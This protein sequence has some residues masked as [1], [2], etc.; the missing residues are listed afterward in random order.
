MER[1]VKFWPYAWCLQLLKSSALLPKRH[2]YNSSLRKIMVMRT[3]GWTAQSVSMNKMYLSPAG[4]DSP[5]KPNEPRR[6][7]KRTS[8]SSCSLG[9]HEN[10]TCKLKC[11][12][13]RS[14]STTYN[15]KELNWSDLKIFKKQVWNWSGQSFAVQAHQKI[16]GVAYTRRL[17]GRLAPFFPPSLACWTKWER[18]VGIKKK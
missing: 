17:D 4:I 12:F 2:L 16:L 15:F 6:S 7:R 10:R 8:G 5:V 18:C 3:A 1:N 14:L 9:H 11:S 13:C